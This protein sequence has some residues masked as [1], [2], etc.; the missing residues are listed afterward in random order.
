MR[1]PR[2][3]T[4]AT[5]TRATG[6]STEEVRRFNPA[7]VRQVPA[8]ASLYL[9]FHV[10]AFGPDVSFWHRPASPSYAVVLHDFLTLDATT[11]Q[12]D[13]PAFQHLL[14]DFER[15]FKATNTEEGDVMSTVLAY[16]RQDLYSS[17]RGAILAEFRTS[18]RILRLFNRAL[19]ARDV[20]R[21]EVTSN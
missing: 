10:E 11:A 14:R 12:W 13:D 5:I 2:A 20:S 7:L 6:L 8:G 3:L 4:L 17:R 16:T 18:E 21:G 15:R 1:T 9:P 19:L